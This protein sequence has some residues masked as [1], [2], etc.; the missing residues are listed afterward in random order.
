M[1]EDKNATVGM[2]SAYRDKIGMLTFVNAVRVVDLIADNM[3]AKFSRVLDAVD[4]AGKILKT[5]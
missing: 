1:S 2:L 5:L 3:F 4:C